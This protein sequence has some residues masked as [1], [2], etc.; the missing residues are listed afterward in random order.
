MDTCF[1]LCSAVKC[2]M[3]IYM[4][5]FSA[6]VTL[7]GFVA[8]FLVFRYKTID[9]YVDSAKDVLRSLLK[10]LID[11]AP[12]ILVIIQ[13]IGKTPKESDPYFIWELINKELAKKRRMEKRLNTCQTKEAAIKFFRL[14]LA[15][16]RSRDI[17]NC[18]GLSSIVM[19][20]V[21]SLAYLIIRVSGPCLF[22]NIRCSAT[23]ILSFSVFFFVI[24]MGFT[25][26]F[27]FYSLR[28]KRPDIVIFE[29]Y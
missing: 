27:V 21:L 24:F 17:I 13:E 18:L 25:L 22:S 20:G 14:I 12:C 8:V 28:A 5:L 1:S 26:Y 4:S 7:A 16:R 11:E 6:S 10:D 3:D 9:T 23:V 15:W 19:W 29:K 2:Y